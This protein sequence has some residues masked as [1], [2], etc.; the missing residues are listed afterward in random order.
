[1]ARSNLRTWAGAGLAFVLATATADASAEQAVAKLMMHGTGMVT[2]HEDASLSKAWAQGEPDMLEGKNVRLS[3]NGMLWG[4]GFDGSLM[5]DGTRFVFGIT[6][7][8]VD[9]THIAYDALPAG[10]RLEAGR[11]WGETLELRVGREFQLGPLFPYIDMR[12]AFMIMAVNTELHGPEYG[13]LGN[14]AY[15]RVSL[16]FGPVGGLFIPL[17]DMFVDLSGY[18]GLFGDESYGGTAGLG[19]WGDL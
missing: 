1:M 7:F 8:G 11:L 16:G 18:A 10:Y 13:Q 12:V 19:V 4:G 9:D 15:N 2:R 6:F 14:V 3:E 17:G 5:F